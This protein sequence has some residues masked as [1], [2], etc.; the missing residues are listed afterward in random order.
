MNTNKT[1]A[2]KNSSSLGVT[3]PNAFGN[4]HQIQMSE[5]DQLRTAANWT[6]HASFWGTGATHL[7]L[8][9]AQEVWEQH[10]KAFSPE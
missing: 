10:D 4:T 5:K 6:V 7:Q 9:V 3:N 1:R 8:T 2:F